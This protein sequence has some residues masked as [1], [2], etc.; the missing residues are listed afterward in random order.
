MTSVSLNRASLSLE[1]RLLLIAYAAFILLGMTAGLLGVGWSSGIRAEFERPRDAA[2]VVLLAITIGYLSASFLNGVFI[3]RIGYGWLFALSGVLTA[4]GMATYTIAPV[5]EIFLLGGLIVG[6][7]T[8]MCDAGLNNY[9][10]AFYSARAMNWL[11]ACFGIGVTLSPLIMT[12]LIARGSNWRLGYGLVFGYSLV[13]LLSLVL[14]QRAWRPPLNVAREPGANEQRVH[15]ARTGQTLRLPVVWLCI[16]LTFLFA[17]LESTPGQWAFDL[18][19]ARGVD[20]L[21]AGQLVSLYWGS[22][23]IGRLL[24]GAIMPALIRVLG[25]TSNVLR[26][27]IVLAMV[28]T[29]LWWWSPIPTAGFIGLMLLGFAQAPLFPVAVSATGGYVGAAHAENTIGF[30]IAGAGAGVALLPGIAGI[31]AT[32]LKNPETLAPFSALAVLM[33]FIIHEALLRQQRP[34]ASAA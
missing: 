18:F 34:K 5:W 22:F 28:G 8:G 20:A 2:G 17:G 32:Q 11:H 25:S 33:I 4:L 30:Q 21:L 9:M 14:N 29:L 31:L 7:G 3:K 13:V 6:F 19:E 26:A 23:T 12:E 24:F 1:R 15:Q 27:V 16:A 10:A